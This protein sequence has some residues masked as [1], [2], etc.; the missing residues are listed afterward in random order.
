MYNGNEMV[1]DGRAG[2]FFCRAPGCAEAI[3]VLNAV[4]MALREGGTC[5]IWSDCAS[6]TTAI[7]NPPHLWPW[8]SASIIAAIKTILVSSDITIIF[9]GRAFVGE[10]DRI[11]R[12]AREDRLPM[13]WVSTMP[14]TQSFL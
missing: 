11:A 1:V 14:S 8:E 6:I 2:N 4:Q 12:L 3:A 5:V 7:D 13:Q 10:A 9:K